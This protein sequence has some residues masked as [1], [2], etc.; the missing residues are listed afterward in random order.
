MVNKMDCAYLE[1]Q[2][3]GIVAAHLKY[4]FQKRKSLENS[5]SSFFVVFADM[6]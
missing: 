1:S 5:K 4:L 6:T 2:D 3:L